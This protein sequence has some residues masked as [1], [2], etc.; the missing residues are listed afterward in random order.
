M[1]IVKSSL[2]E[3][4]KGTLGN[5]IFYKVG[6]QIR[7]RGKPGR[8]KDQKSPKQMIQRNK[9]KEI[10]RLYHSLDLQLMVFWKQL[11]AG[12]TLNGYNLFMRENI[13]N[14]NKEAHITDFSKLKVCE[15][16]LLLPEDIGSIITPDNMISIQWKYS[17]DDPP[18]WESCLQII[19]YTP[20]KKRNPKIRIIHTTQVEQD[21]EKYDF[22]IPK[23][24]EMPAH[25]F[26]FFK[27]CLTND[28]SPSHYIGSIEQED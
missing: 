27:S 21:A 20:M 12:T 9:V 14:L 23:N 13:R 15:G 28:V 22:L 3:D 16:T 1:A 19:A 5:T 18:K 2:F 7:T 25:F 24:I 6:D 8:Y 10:S 4:F 26:I 17:S 11:V